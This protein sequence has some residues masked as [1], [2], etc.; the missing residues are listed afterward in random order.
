M[1]EK[2]PQLICQ[3]KTQWFKVSR[4][5]SPVSCSAHCHSKSYE[6]TGVQESSLF[7]WG[8]RFLKKKNIPTSAYL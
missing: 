4:N 1:A 7:F 3:M 5:L 2:I 6:M 8:T